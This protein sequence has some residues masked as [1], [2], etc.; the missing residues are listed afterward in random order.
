M[1]PRYTINSQ[2]VQY[3]SPHNFWLSRP[4]SNVAPSGSH[5]ATQMNRY[6]RKRKADVADA[7]IREG[8]QWHPV[9][10]TTDAT[11][12]IIKRKGSERE[13]LSLYCCRLFRWPFFPGKKGLLVQSFQGTIVLGF[14]TKEERRKWDDKFRGLRTIEA[15]MFAYAARPVQFVAPSNQAKYF[16]MC[17]NGRYNPEGTYHNSATD[18]ADGFAPNRRRR[19]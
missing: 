2:S 3:S 7:F 4:H 1:D 14:D 5:F 12:L 9:K 17:K 18:Y 11:I 10:I 19:H 16:A 6:S 15:N 13:S 8:W